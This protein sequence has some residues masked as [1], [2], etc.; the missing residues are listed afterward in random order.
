MDLF[1]KPPVGARHG[2]GIVQQLVVGLNHLAQHPDLFGG[3]MAGG[4]V[5]S[6]PFQFTAH[7][8]KLGHLVVVQRRHDQAAPV[9]RQQRLRLEPLQG[10]ADGC[11]R[12]A[13]PVGQLAFHQ[14]VA[15]AVLP[16]VDGFEDHRIGVGV[17]WFHHALRPWAVLRAP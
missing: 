16:D 2:G 5:G 14:P 12:H 1:V 15:R 9:A 11:A 13:E 3:G 17:H 7:H 4:Q 6:Q 8:I 10:L